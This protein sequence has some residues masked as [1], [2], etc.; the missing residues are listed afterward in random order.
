MP[1]TIVYG[2]L[3]LPSGKTIKFRKPMGLDRS[4]VAQMNAI[5]VDEVVSGSL[6]QQNHLMAKVITE[7]DG[8]TEDGTK[9]QTLFNTWEDV[10]IQYYQAVYTEMFG[11]SEQRQT[12]AKAK[13]AF[14][15]KSSTSTD[16]SN[17]ANSVPAP[18]P[19]GSTP[20]TP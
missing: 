19:N 5:G 12:D 17:S 11:L 8:K 9:F 3:E 4:N 20:T 2:P 10:D 6:R 1:D 7:V 13:A 18:T 15:L 14:L 16:G